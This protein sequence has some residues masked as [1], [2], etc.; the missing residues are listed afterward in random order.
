MVH[1]VLVPANNGGPL[2]V[3][4]PISYQLKNIWSAALYPGYVIDKDRLA[5]A[6]IGYTGATIG[7][8]SSS[9]TYQTT[10]LTG[11]VLGLGYK[12]MVTQSVYL[13]GE[14]NYAGYS[15]KATTLV[16]TNGT[17]SST[18]GGS[19]MDFLVGVGYRF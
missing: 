18:V 13:L 11:Y 14:V 19:G 7:I 4:S 17:F 3:T 15:N 6:K 9:A 8:N 10:N 2:S 12:Q 1:L 16:S 5:Y